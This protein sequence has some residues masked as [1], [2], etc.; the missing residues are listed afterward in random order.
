MQIS[1]ENKSHQLSVWQLQIDR[2]KR[3]G[4]NLDELIECSLAD[5]SLSL[6]CHTMNRQCL[7]RKIPIEKE[8]KKKERKKNTDR[9]QR[10]LS[11]IEK[12]HAF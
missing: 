7:S 12:M 2:V 6:P 8:K 11:K 4:V 1:K 3:S 10:N 5:D 9:T